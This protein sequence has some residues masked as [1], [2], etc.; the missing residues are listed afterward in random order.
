MVAPVGGEHRGARGQCLDRV[1]ERLDQLPAP[2]GQHGVGGGGGV[3]PVRAGGEVPAE[4]VGGEQALVAHPRQGQAV[5]FAE[6]GAQ[7]PDGGVVVGLVESG[8]ADPP[9]HGRLDVVVDRGLFAVG[10]AEHHVL[11]G[12]GGIADGDQHRAG[13]VPPPGPVAPANRGSG[14]PGSSLAAKHLKPVRPRPGVQRRA[15]APQFSREVVGKPRGPGLPARKQLVEPAHSGETLATPRDRLPP[16]GRRGCS[17]SAPPLLPRLPQAPTTQGDTARPGLTQLVEWH[18]CQQ[19]SLHGVDASTALRR[20]VPGQLAEW[21]MP[22]HSINPSFRISY[23]CSSKVFSF[24]LRRVW[25]IGCE[26]GGHVQQG[27]DVRQVAGCPVEASPM[28]PGLQRLRRVGPSEERQRLLGCR[29]SSPQ[30]QPRAAIRVGCLHQ[31][32]SCALLREALGLESPPVP[33]GCLFAG[34]FAFDSPTGLEVSLQC[35][36]SWHDPCRLGTVG[37]ANR[38]GRARGP[39]GP[40]QPVP[41][42]ALQGTPNPL[43]Q[44]PGSVQGSKIRFTLP[45]SEP[46]MFVTCDDVS[47]AVFS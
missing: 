27:A 18:F 11:A 37:T 29:L 20:E 6:G 32:P 38:G 23:T 41:A 13:P 19:F 3:G 39:V 31:P 45:V 21:T 46:W 47:F 25:S 16:G 1:A 17:Q 2:L 4:D 42:D 28:S 33:S 34:V 30:K 7:Q 5:E 36:A 26:R 12:I 44:N 40:F 35:S 10:A 22:A 24:L 15:S 9:G 8:G 14:G 43:A